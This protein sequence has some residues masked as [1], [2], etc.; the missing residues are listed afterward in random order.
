MTLLGYKAGKKIDGWMM[1]GRHIADSESGVLSLG[2]LNNLTA[3][4]REK[5]E[6]YF[7]FSDLT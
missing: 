7:S 6:S 3:K 1:D 4:G 5:G 2:E